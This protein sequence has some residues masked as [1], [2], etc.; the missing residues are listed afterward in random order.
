MLRKKGVQLRPPRAVRGPSST[1]L[2]RLL[3]LGRLLPWHQEDLDSA[4]LLSAQKLK[5][6][7]LLTHLA[8]L[9]NSRLV[10]LD[11]S[12]KGPATTLLEELLQAVVGGPLAYGCAYRD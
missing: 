5:A 2:R 7:S 4:L 9:Q 8:V 3:L 11:T 6:Y 10:V 12:E 1:L